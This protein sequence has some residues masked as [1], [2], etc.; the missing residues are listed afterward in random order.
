MNAESVSSR[1]SQPWATFCIHAPMLETSA[2]IQKIRYRRR[3]QRG[4][5]RKRATFDRDRFGARDLRSRRLAEDA[6]GRAH[7]FEMDRDRVRHVDRI[8]AAERGRYRDAAP[9]TGA[10]D[11]FVAATQT[12]P[13]DTEATQ[14]VAFVRV[15]AGLVEDEVGS[16]FVEDFR[17]RRVE[18]RQ[19]EARRRPTG[20][21][22]A[23]GRTTRD[24]CPGR[25][26][27]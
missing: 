10:E 5:E 17:Q 7:G 8:S 9:E 4:P 1:T 2:P 27:P 11:G 19:V 25:C 15:R 24:R 20:S 6:P 3:P 16:R 18:G 26:A 21:L 14:L 13:R 23:S 22:S 12:V